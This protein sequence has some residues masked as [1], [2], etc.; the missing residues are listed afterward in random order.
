[1]FADPKMTAT[2]LDELLCN[3]WKFTN[4]T[5]NAVIRLDTR[6]DGGTTAWQISDNG[7]GFNMAYA[8]KLFQPFERLHGAHEYEGA[9][10]GLAICRRIIERHGGSIQAFGEINKGVTISF[11][12]PTN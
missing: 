1:L 12:L 8:K 4:R 3:A 7:A 11:T 9:G 10:L 5:P 2:L 6:Q